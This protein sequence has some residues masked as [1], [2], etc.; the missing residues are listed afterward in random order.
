M[1][2]HFHTLMT[3]TAILLACAC[4]VSSSTR[5]TTSS[6]STSSLQDTAEV[7]APVAN[8]LSS[9]SLIR[10]RTRRGIFKEARKKFVG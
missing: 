5:D 8:E 10:M 1:M 4:V 3:V 6:R 9:R 7:G 2:F